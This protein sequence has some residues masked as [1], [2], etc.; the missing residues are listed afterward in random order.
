MCDHGF[1]QQ[2]LQPWPILLVCEC[3]SCIKSPVIRG[4]GLPFTL[5][6]TFA[7]SAHCVRAWCLKRRH[8]EYVSVDVH[9]RN[10]P[11]P[12]FGLLS[13][14]T[15]SCKVEPPFTRQSG[16]GKRIPVPCR[17]GSVLNVLEDPIHA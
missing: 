12:H 1:G 3:S 17:N 14:G 13:I 6:V 5:R 15:S 16:Y 7:Y 9:V 11:L 10:T 4:L 8:R 2:G